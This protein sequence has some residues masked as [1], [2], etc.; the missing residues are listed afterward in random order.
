MNLAG[1]SWQK[2][3]VLVMHTSGVIGMKDNSCSGNQFLYQAVS[4]FV[5][6]YFVGNILDEKD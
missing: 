2:V 5:W 4:L 1:D 3:Y 6:H